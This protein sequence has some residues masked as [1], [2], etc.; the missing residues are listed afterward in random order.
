MTNQQYREFVKETKYKTESEKFGWSFV[1]D[2]L[3]SDEVREANTQTVKDAPQWVAVE[4]SWWRAPEGK[5]SNLQERWDHPVVQ[6]SWNDA[7]EFCKWAGKRLPSEAEV[8]PRSIPVSSF[9]PPVS[10]SL[11]LSSQAVP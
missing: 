11:R 6:V 9:L 3:L 1:L 10:P 5:G 4:G 8:G 2:L 7:K